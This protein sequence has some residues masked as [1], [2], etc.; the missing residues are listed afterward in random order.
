[1][2]GWVLLQTI[3]IQ[4]SIFYSVQSVNIKQEREKIHPEVSTRMQEEVREKLKNKEAN[5]DLKEHFQHG[6]ALADL[7]A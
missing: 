4:F 3:K 7:T 2:L 6:I 5:T 1:M